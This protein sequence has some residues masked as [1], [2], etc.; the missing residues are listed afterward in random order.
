MTIEMEGFQPSTVTLNWTST[1]GSFIFHHG[2]LWFSHPTY[3]SSNWTQHIK[4]LVNFINYLEPPCLLDYNYI[5]VPLPTKFFV[6]AYL[7]G[8]GVQKFF[9]FG[10]KPKARVMLVFNSSMP[11]TWIPSP[12]TYRA[13]FRTRIGCERAS[14]QKM[15]G[16]ASQMM[17]SMEHFWWSI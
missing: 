13:T 3:V 7:N 4:S 2:E 17:F 10:H 5:V 14:Y 9:T 6:N 1:Y 15:W 11:S 8:E 12:A 16:R